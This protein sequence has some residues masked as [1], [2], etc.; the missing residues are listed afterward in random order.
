MS[1]NSEDTVP[2]ET[3]Y[4]PNL[5]IN[6][7]LSFMGFHF[8]FYLSFDP[9]T[10]LGR[11]A[12]REPVFKVLSCVQKKNTENV[13]MYGECLSLVRALASGDFG[14]FMHLLFLT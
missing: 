5:D 9:T 14:S 3:A 10:H 7:P 4:F 2:E 8:V 6:S 13:Y 12:W 1:K 11:E